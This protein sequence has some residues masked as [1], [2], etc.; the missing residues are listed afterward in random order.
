MKPGLAHKLGTTGN[1]V[2]VSQQSNKYQTNMIAY[3]N[4]DI[5]LEVRGAFTDGDASKSGTST[6]YSNSDDDVVFANNLWFAEV[7]YTVKDVG[8][9]LVSSKFSH[10]DY[11]VAAFLEPKLADLKALTSL[12][13]FTFEMNDEKAAKQYAL[14]VDARARY[15]INDQLSVTGMFNWTAGDKISSGENKNA[16]YAS[17]GMVNV[18]YKMNDTIQPFCSVIYSAGTKCGTVEEIKFDTQYKAS[19]RIYPGVSIFQT[20]N[21]NIIS[22]VA[23]DISDVLHSSDY[24]THGKLNNMTVTIP[25]LMRVKF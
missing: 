8:R 9:I 11:T 13:G 14:A 24:D 4:K 17:W 6:V 5:G 7:G 18:T 15:A 12:L 10:R 22:G 23:L 2:D 3:V 1:G 16:E 19:L 21:A 25:V 20:K